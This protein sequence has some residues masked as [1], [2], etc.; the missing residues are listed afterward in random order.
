M[1]DDMGYADLSSYGSTQYQ[2]PNLDELAKQGIRFLQAY[3][4]APVCT[5][6]RT[7][8]ITGQY[9]ARTQVGLWEPLTGQDVDQ[10]IGLTAHNITLSSLL[11]Q[12]GYQTV[13]IGKWHLGKQP[14]HHPNQHGFEEFYGVLEGAADYI[15]HQPGLYH[16][17]QLMKQ[18]GYLT[19]LFTGKA[20]AFLAQP[21]TKP[22]FMSLQYTAPHWPWQGPD[23]APYPDSVSWTGGGSIQTYAQMMQSLDKSIGQLMAGLQQNGLEEN[24][25]V[26]FTS[27][28]GGERFSQMGP[29][30][31]KKME[32]WEGGIRVPAI[33]RWPKVLK[34]GNES[35]QVVISMDWTATILAA[36]GAKSHTGYTLD[37]INLLP[38]CRGEAP[39]QIRQ[40]AWRTFQRTKYK[41]FRSGDWKYLSDSKA[42][43]VFN[44]AKDPG[45]EHDLKTEQPKR[46]AQLKALYLE[47]ESQMLSPVALPK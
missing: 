23:D 15:S 21:H 33:M 24:T 36:T 22:F 17:T 18:E 14:Q 25:L 20:L 16:N 45:E 12:Q 32:L 47:W 4:A 43:Y 19:D 8:F 28:N 3:A 30:R 40:L 9:P 11:K 34:G 44:L 38:I 46:L 2:T 41:A 26:I 35:N 7:G 42:E 37:G 6:S 31:G 39:I 13:L 5:P 1:V 10:Q 29:F 27:D